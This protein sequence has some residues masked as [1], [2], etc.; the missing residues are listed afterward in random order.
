M[1]KRTYVLL[2]F[3][4]ESVS[5]LASKQQQ[6]KSEVCA[7]NLRKKSLVFSSPFFLF[8]AGGNDAKV[9]AVNIKLGGKKKNMT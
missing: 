3:C 7:K 2:M 8:V 4:E 6:Q 5:V 9:P 1:L